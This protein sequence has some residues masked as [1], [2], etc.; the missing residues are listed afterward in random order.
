[1]Y[2]NAET[3]L[4]SQLIRAEQEAPRTRLLPLAITYEHVRL[5]SFN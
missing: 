4:L 5:Y 2:T 3:V 1:M